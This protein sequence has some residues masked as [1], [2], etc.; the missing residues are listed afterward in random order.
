MT[1]TNKSTETPK[2]RF[3]AEFEAL[4]LDEK[5]AHLLKMEAA[6]ISEAFAFAVN[7]PMKVVEKVGD[8]ISEFG[9]RIEAEVKKARQTCEPPASEPTSGPGPAKKKGRAPRKGGPPPPPATPPPPPVG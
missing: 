2:D 3:Q 9:T 7:S 4:P 6:T 5:F 1:E 8:V